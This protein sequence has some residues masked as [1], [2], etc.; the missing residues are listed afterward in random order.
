MV[1]GYFCILAKRQPI[2]HH[3]QEKRIDIFPIFFFLKE[4]NQVKRLK[5]Q[6]DLVVASQEYQSRA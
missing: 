4:M 5:H 1:D 3:Q 2:F 6:H